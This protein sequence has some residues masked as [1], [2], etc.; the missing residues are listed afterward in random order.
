MIDS[1][2]NSATTSFSM[3][4]IKEFVFKKKKKIQQLGNERFEYRTFP[5]KTPITVI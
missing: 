4:K 2:I 5:L 3:Y 1:V